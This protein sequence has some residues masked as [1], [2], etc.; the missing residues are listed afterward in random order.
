LAIRDQAVLQYQST[1]LRAFQ[2]VSNALVTRQK[3]AEAVTAQARAV[4]AY[5]ESVKLALERYRLGK[6]NYYEVLQQQQ[7]LFPTERA[8]LQNRLN[9]YLATVQLYRA[10][11]GGWQT[12]T[13]TAAKTK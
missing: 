8:L 1:I 4:D 10:L 13:N 9:E 6:S 11:G 3:S 7:Q 5:K 2:D 12:S